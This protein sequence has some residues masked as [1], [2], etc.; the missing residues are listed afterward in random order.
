MILRCFLASDA[1]SGSTPITLLNTVTHVEQA[2]LFLS[3]PF[4]CGP[5][6]CWVYS[7]CPI[8]YSLSGQAGRP[9]LIHRLISR[10]LPPPDLLR[11]FVAPAA[12][13]CTTIPLLNTPSEVKRAALL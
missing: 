12:A 2:A 5:S 4:L 1:A 11:F 3:A 8:E 9:A 10:P 13:G 6:H 7:N